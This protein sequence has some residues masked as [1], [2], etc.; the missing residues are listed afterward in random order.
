MSNL[1]NWTSLAQ[2]FRFTAAISPPNAQ[3]DQA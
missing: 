1:S 3:A 2:R